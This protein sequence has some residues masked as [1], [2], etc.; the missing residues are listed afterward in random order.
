LRRCLWRCR[1]R[2]GSATETETHVEHA[3]QRLHERAE[4]LAP[5][6]KTEL[7]A[8]DVEDC[9]DLAQL[10]PAF[11]VTV[12][13]SMQ[14]LVQQRETRIE[15]RSNLGRGLQTVEIVEVQ[16]QAPDHMNA[17]VPGVIDDH[18]A[19]IALSEQD[20]VGSG[21]ILDQE[22]SSRTQRPHEGAPRRRRAVRRFGIAQHEP[23]VRSKMQ[24]GETRDPS[25]AA[26]ELLLVCVGEDGVRIPGA[27][28]AWSRQ[29]LGLRARRCAA[30]KESQKQREPAQR[31]PSHAQP[32]VASSGGSTRRLPCIR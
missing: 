2:A 30:E 23:A 8:H 4:I 11:G 20:R 25:Q 18:R 32:L 27:P 12:S 13:Q 6:R 24:T 29:L 10:S 22:R 21:M 26:Q 14:Q 15:G 16:P 5:Q 7:V 1:V 31:D 9:F 17:V 28:D 19:W 3:A